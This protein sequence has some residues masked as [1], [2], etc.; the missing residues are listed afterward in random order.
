MTMR[1]LR[2]LASILSGCGIVNF[3]DAPVGKFQGEVL[4]MWVGETTAEVL[5]DKCEP[6]SVGTMTLSLT[7]CKGRGSR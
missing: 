3:A 4:V 2:L 5:A 6:V 7:R 1:W